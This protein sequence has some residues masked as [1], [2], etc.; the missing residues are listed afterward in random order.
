MRRLLLLTTALGALCAPAVAD[1]LDVFP[2]ENFYT[3]TFPTNHIEGDVTASVSFYNVELHYQGYL[4][5]AHEIG[6]YFYMYGKYSDGLWT[7]EF[8]QGSR[9]QR[10]ISGG[11]YNVPATIHLDP[12]VDTLVFRLWDYQ[13]YGATAS[14]RVHLDFTDGLLNPP[15]ELAT[16]LPRTLPLMLTGLGLMGLLGWRRNRIPA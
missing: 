1:T 10:F 4:F 3:L 5:D 14:Q 8:V 2:T 9:D 7:K 16:P 12:L 15:T 13:A 6:A 11:G